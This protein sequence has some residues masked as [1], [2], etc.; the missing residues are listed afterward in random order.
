MPA[1]FVDSCEADAD[2]SAIVNAR[3]LKE[4]QAAIAGLREALEAILWCVKPHA[5]SALTSA[6]PRQTCQLVAHV[7]HR[8]LSPGEYPAKGSR[9][10]EGDPLA[11]AIHEAR[12]DAEVLRRYYDSPSSATVSLSVEA[13]RQ[14]P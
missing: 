6:D 2:R 9:F 8:A 5:I 12:L 4:A 1:N 7:A 14:H 13:S 3:D 11:V 10:Y